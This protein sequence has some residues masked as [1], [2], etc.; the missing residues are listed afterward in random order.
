MSDTSISLSGSDHSTSASSDMVDQHKI[1]DGH[2]RKGNNS[3]YLASPLSFNWVKIRDAISAL[4]VHQREALDEVLEEDPRLVQ[5]ESPPHRYLQVLGC[6]RDKQ[7]G[8]SI[9]S[10]VAQ[11]IADYW[12]ERKFVFGPDRFTRPLK[13]NE[14]V[15]DKP[16]TAIDPDTMQ[17]LRTGAYMI[18]PPQA[19]GPC[20]L[21]VLLVDRAKQVKRKKMVQT[22]VN[23]YLFQTIFLSWDSSEFVAICQLEE[24]MRSDQLGEAF[25]LVGDSGILPL[26]PR[27]IHV[28]TMRQQMRSETDLKP[29]LLSSREWNLRGSIQF[30]SHMCAS[31]AEAQSCL[32]RYGFSK[33]YLTERFGGTASG[34]SL[35]QGCV[36]PE[37]A[38]SG[39]ESAGPIM[40][41]TA[42]DDPANAGLKR[43]V[44]ELQD[45]SSERSDQRKKAR[46]EEQNASLREQQKLLLAQLV[47]VHYIIKQYEHD[48]SIIQTHAAKVIEAFVASSKLREFQ[49]CQDSEQHSLLADILLSEYLVFR[50]RLPGTGEWVFDITSRPVSPAVMRELLRLRGDFLK[51]QKGKDEQATHLHSQ[52]PETCV[53]DDVDKE[54]SALK[55]QVERLQVQNKALRDKEGFFQSLLVCANHTADQHE[56]DAKEIR[57]EILD[58]LPSLFPPSDI[59]LG[60]P[61]S[62]AHLVDHLLEK[63]V[64]FLGR[65]PSTGKHMYEFGVGFLQQMVMV[66][67][68]QEMSELEQA[69]EEQLLDQT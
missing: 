18:I 26:N 67:S 24:D 25:K 29:A 48:Q 35:C 15:E 23:F 52:V 49:G 31:Q 50:G 7:G 69:S 45:W 57:Q 3:A 16:S 40:V 11:R 58:S 32:R 20:K 65:N 28:L 43:M 34:M 68:R 53:T 10:E 61:S 54:V 13:L 37:K 63:Y 9:E 56:Q 36:S 42:E 59:S 55:D 51:L 41:S 6:Q 8:S 46:I 33:A 1:A 44:T 64:V 14:S 19:C 39:S 27:A 47:C 62:L 38:K 21:P 5:L 60:E 66:S 2:P 30:V 22:Q 12:T 4:P 17:E